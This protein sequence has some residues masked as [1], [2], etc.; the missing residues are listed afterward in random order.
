M[1]YFLKKLKNNP[2]IVQDF[3][4]WDAIEVDANTHFLISMK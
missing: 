2:L 1:K 3:E 4:I